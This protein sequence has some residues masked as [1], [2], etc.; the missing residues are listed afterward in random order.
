MSYVGDLE[1]EV[2]ELKIVISALMDRADMGGKLV[3]GQEELVKAR[4]YHDIKIEYGSDLQ[5]M[6]VE[7]RPTY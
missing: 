2:E 6:I 4:T 1:M 3:L 7:R 5:G